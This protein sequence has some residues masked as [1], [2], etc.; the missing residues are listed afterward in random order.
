L[1]LPEHRRVTPARY[2]CPILEQITDSSGIRRCGQSELLNHAIGIA[3]K[4]LRSNAD[5]SGLIPASSWAQVASSLW[6]SAPSFSRNRQRHETKQDKTSA[7]LSTGAARAR[8]SSLE[9]LSPK[10]SVSIYT[11]AI[12]EDYRWY[13]CRTCGWFFFVE[14]VTDL[15]FAEA[16]NLTTLILTTRFFG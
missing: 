15:Q 11:P 14:D 7:V 1:Q 9:T 8:R 4:T 3:S 13:N 10:T 6:T 12:L 2:T 16:S 5:H